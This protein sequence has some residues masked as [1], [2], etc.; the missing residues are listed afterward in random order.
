MRDWKRSEI[1]ASF[2]VDRSTSFEA[3]T[4]Y[5]DELMSQVPYRMWVGYY[6]LLLSH[7]GVRP[8]RLL[9]IACGTGTMT[10]MLHE[11]GMKMAGFDLSPG[12]IAEARRKA[13]SLNIDIRYEV[14]DAA[15]ADMDDRY[16]GAYSFFDSLNNI[17]DPERL[18]MAFDRAYEHL[19]PGGS[20]IFDMNT[21]YAFE[22]KMFDQ[23]HLRKTSTLRYDW[24]GDYDPSTKIIRVDM[25]FW[26]GNREFH[27]THIQRAYDQDEVRAMLEA[28][29]FV[30]IRPFHS[31]TLNPPRHSS[32]RLHWAVLKP[33]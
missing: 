3:V 12:M 7:Q 30:D 10:E 2:S 19:E 32:D 11:E 8:R 20:F 25:K 9:D 14:F 4:P 28:S 21:A 33:D 31:Y 22:Q 17:T 13:D 26:Y 23:R 29:G 5:Y 15:A 27:E 16:D 24:K 6:L 1:V 18:Q